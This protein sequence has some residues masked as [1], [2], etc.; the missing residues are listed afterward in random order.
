[1]QDILRILRK[2]VSTVV[3]FTAFAL[4]SIPSS[5]N[6]LECNEWI[7]IGSHFREGDDGCWV[8]CYTG[9]DSYW[10]WFCK[11]ATWH[12]TVLIDWECSGNTV[13]CSNGGAACIMSL[14]QDL[15]RL[16]CSCRLN[17]PPCSGSWCNNYT[18]RSGW[19]ACYVCP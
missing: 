5:S 11:D 19:Q 16:S 2:A 18:Y 3:V 9:P 10:C 17:Y 14:R 7:D 12:E 4:L 15:I 6:A 8:R 13:T 1:M